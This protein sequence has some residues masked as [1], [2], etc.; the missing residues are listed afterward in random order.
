MEDACFFSLTSPSFLSQASFSRYA[1]NQ[2]KEE[3]V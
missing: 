1:L 3:L 2:I